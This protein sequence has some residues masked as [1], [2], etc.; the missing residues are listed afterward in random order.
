MITGSGRVIP[1]VSG[2]ALHIEQGAA[3]RL[4]AST[5]MIV[6]EIETP[7]DKF[8][9]VRLADDKPRSTSYDGAEHVTPLLDPLEPVGGGPPRA[10]LR[11][12]AAGARHRFSLVRGNALQQL[13]PE[14]EFA[15][16][17]E[18]L[19]ILRRDIVIL[20]PATLDAAIADQLYLTI[21]RARDD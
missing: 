4:V 15:I 8:D 9:L 19:G 1:F 13:R 16:S 20:D 10:R 7:R 14:V 12:P 11:R 2:G 17:L 18:A 3:H 5:D 21:H 6:V